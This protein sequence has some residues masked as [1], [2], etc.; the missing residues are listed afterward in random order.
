MAPRE[1]LEREINKMTN[2]GGEMLTQ[3]VAHL[4]FRPGSTY[5]VV[6]RSGP[7][8]IGPTMQF[9]PIQDRT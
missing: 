7:V 9:G 2:E 8:R 5:V 6:P 3:P 4:L 1:P